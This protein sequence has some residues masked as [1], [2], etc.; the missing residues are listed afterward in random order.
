MGK[1]EERFA[2]GVRAFREGVPRNTNLDFDWQCGWDSAQ[3]RK[4]LDY[5][6]Y[7]KARVLFSKEYVPPSGRGF[8][9]EKLQL[10]RRKTIT[11]LEAE[12]PDFKATY[13]KNK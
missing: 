3:Q 12:Y 9:L 13:E 7:I 8:L 1:V 11:K 5:K 10:A 2:E 4:I 6:D